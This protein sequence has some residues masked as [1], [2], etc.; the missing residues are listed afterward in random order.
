MSFQHFMSEAII[1]A[2]EALR[3]GS[4]PVGAIV[5]H[6]E[7]IVAR[8]KN[9]DAC[10]ILPRPWRHA[11][12]VAAAKACQRLERERLKGETVFVTLEPCPMCAEALRLMRVQ[13]VVFGA[14]DPVF[15]AYSP[16]SAWPENVIGGVCET[17]CRQLLLSFFAERR[18]KK[19]EWCE[20]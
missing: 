16:H 10:G 12:L 8:A 13:K 3:K 20:R 7:E 19:K 1:E 11:E 15:G 5:S 2:R 14:Y 6:S 17:E 9:D 4:V 18:A